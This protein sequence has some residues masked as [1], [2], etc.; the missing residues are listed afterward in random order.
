MQRH[1]QAGLYSVYMVLIQHAL[2]SGSHQAQRCSLVCGAVHTAIDK[3]GSGVCGGGGKGAEGC[4]ALAG[5]A[6]CGNA[7]RGV[8]NV[9]HRVGHHGCKEAGCSCRCWVPATGCNVT[10]HGS[11]CAFWTASS[12]TG[13][14]VGWRAAAASTSLDLGTEEMDQGS[15]KLRLEQ[16]QRRPSTTLR[17]FIHLSA[18]SNR[19][20]WIV[21]WPLEAHSKGGW[22]SGPLNASE[23]TAAG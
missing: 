2:C 21:P 4:N 23:C 11:S 1:A 5:Q 7:A 13:T 19:K 22:M 10:V 12:G 16:H 18:A 6:H 8:H 9:P 3:A 20:M 17:Q 15:Q 14:M